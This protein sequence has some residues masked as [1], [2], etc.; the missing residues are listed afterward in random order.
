MSVL[1]SLKLE[2][3]IFFKTVFPNRVVVIRSLPTIVKHYFCFFIIF[4]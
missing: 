3:V 2:E 4:F 1:R